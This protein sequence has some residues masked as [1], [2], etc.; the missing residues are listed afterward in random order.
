MDRLE[1]LGEPLTELREEP[2]LPRELFMTNMCWDEGWAGKLMPGEKE[3][4]PR[5][6]FSPP[7]FQLQQHELQVMPNQFPRKWGGGLLP[8]HNR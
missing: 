3:L 5:R 1:A 8:V 7:M 4:R 2:V 6:E